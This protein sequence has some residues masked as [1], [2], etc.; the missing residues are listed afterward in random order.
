MAL[1][2]RSI[3][4]TPYEIRHA[5]EEIRAQIGGDS[6]LKA[7]SLLKFG[8]NSTVGTSYVTVQE[9]GGNEIYL[10]S[11]LIDSVIST[12]A[13][14]TQEI[15]IEG[16]YIDGNGDFI[17]HKQQA[18][19]N[20]QNRVALTT[21]LARA[22]RVANIDSTEFAGTVYVH[23]QDTYSSGVPDTASKI[24]V[25]MSASDQQSL[26]AAT[27]ISKNDYW[28]ITSALIGVAQKSG[29]PI[30]TFKIQVREKGGVFRTRATATTSNSQSVPITLNPPITVPAN[31]DVR[32]QAKSSTSNTEVEAWMNGYLAQLRSSA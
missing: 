18:T 8:R 9:H 27:T 2:D 15:E 24:H 16:H 28:I 11:N 1:Q 5:I 21:P 7:K 17:F 14:N 10:S 13:G 4:F 25:I 23:Q 30:V 20:G 3:T 22:T 31:S 19:L 29:A 26:K 12:N 32:I 6:F